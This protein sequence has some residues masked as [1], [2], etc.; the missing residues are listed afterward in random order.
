MDSKAIARDSTVVSSAG[1]VVPMVLSKPVL[2]SVMIEIHRTQRRRRCWPNTAR[3]LLLGQIVEVHVAPGPWHDIQAFS[4]RPKCNAGTP[5]FQA[6]CVQTCP[7]RCHLAIVLYLCT[8]EP[9][10]KTVAS[11]S[12]VAVAIVC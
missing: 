11:V 1:V 12:A 5:L 10:Y 9:A 8:M 7:Q 6:I 3:V 2:P 4:S